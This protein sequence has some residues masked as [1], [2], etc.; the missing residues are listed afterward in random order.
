MTSCARA[1]SLLGPVSDGLHPGIRA[2][3]LAPGV[4]QLS[5]Q[6]GDRKRLEDPSFIFSLTALEGPHPAIPKGDVAILVNG[7]AG[8]AILKAGSAPSVRF[9]LPD[10]IVL[11]PLQ[12]TLGRYE[13]PDQF[14]SAPLTATL[15]PASVQAMA[16]ATRITVVADSLRMDVPYTTLTSLHDVF[17]TGLCGYGPK[18][19]PN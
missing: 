9:E 18:A 12:I 3:N 11:R 14:A 19:S 4:M 7:P 1:D 15:T 10:S 17:R 16:L 6:S 13:G 2:T 8:L 5:T